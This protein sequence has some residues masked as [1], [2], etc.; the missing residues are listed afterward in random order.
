MPPHPPPQ[1]LSW[2]EPSDIH[3]NLISAS[4]PSLLMSQVLSKYPRISDP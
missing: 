1:I 4:S 3:L 2:V